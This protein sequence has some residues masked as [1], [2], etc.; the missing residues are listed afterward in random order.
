MMHFIEE[1]YKEKAEFKD[2]VSQ[3]Y[4]FFHYLKFTVV[5]Y[6]YPLQA[7]Q[8]KSYSFRSDP[9]GKIL[10]KFRDKKLSGAQVNR[11]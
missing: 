9:S 3:I 4:A 8:N 6:E 1:K 2:L 10:A 5:N 11:C 7:K